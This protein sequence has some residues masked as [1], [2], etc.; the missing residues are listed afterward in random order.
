MRNCSI[1]SWGFG[2]VLLTSSAQA[3]ENDSNRDPL[4]VRHTE[5]VEINSA[6]PSGMNQEWIE[7]VRLG[8]LRL[9]GCA[10]ALVSSDGL[11]ATSAGCLRSLES[12]IRPNDSP[13]VAEDLSQEQRLAGLTVNQLVDIQEV[14]GIHG[15]NGSPASGQRTEIIVDEDRR[16]FWEYSWNVYDDVRIVVIP[17]VEVTKFGSEDG[18]YPRFTVDFALV[19][20]YD[21][22]GQPLD[23]ESYFA[24]SDRPPYSR[25]KLFMTAYDGSEMFTLV[26]QSSTYRYNGTLAPLYTTLYGMLDQYHSHGATGFWA[27]P[28]EWDTGIRQGNLSAALNFSVSGECAQIG[29]AIIDIDMEILGIAFDS[30]NTEVGSRCVAVSTAGILSIL[31]SVFNA[32]GV[33]EELANQSLDES[34]DR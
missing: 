24:W 5:F 9:S 25:E 4:R 34:D 3:Q 10:A 26:T 28:P 6:S 21:Q 14:S 31:E 15:S 22:E 1:L 2:L 19:R 13:F 8:T 18:V 23:T 17:P 20:I 32:H 27:L 33:I 30:A 12:W 16:R 11:A 7:Q 29:S